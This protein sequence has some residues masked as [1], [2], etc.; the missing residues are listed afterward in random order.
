MVDSTIATD[1]LVFAL[2]VTQD[3]NNNTETM[4]GLPNRIG[5]SLLVETG[6]QDFKD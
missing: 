1:Q 4:I 5:I 6:L 2:I 3:S